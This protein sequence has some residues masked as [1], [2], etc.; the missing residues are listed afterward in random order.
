[1]SAAVYVLCALTSGLCAVL[2][3]RGYRRTRVKL[4]LWSCLCFVGLAIN[5]VFLV[6]DV[7]VVPEVDLSI[8][9]KVPS[10]FGVGA[11]VCGLIWDAE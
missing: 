7:L 8:W 10:L 1:M 11:L 2:L 6:V 5:N 3:V 9:R 4:L